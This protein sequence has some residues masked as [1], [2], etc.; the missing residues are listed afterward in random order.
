M[1]QKLNIFDIQENFIMNAL[2]FDFYLSA[3]IILF[4]LLFGEVDYGEDEKL[5]SE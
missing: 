3:G 2:W 5:L 4:C 1:K